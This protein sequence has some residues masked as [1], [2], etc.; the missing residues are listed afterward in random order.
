MGDDDYVASPKEY[1]KEKSQMK[2]PKFPFLPKGMTFVSTCK[3][4]KK[5]IELSD[6]YWIHSS[7]RNALCDIVNPSAEPDST[8]E[9]RL[10]P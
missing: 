9:A 10:S 3:H 5:P 1:A 2:D 8:W 4:C 6:N 7:D